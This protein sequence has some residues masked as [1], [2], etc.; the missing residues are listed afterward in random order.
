MTSYEQLVSAVYGPDPGPR[1]MNGSRY[2][3]RRE[4]SE[5]GELPHR[6]FNPS[7]RSRTTSTSVA[8]SDSDEKTPDQQPE[9]APAPEANAGAPQASDTESRLETAKRFLQEDAVKNSPQEK[10]VEF[11]RSKGLTNDEIESLLGREPAQESESSSE[12]RFP[13]SHGR[14][15]IANTRCH[16]PNNPN[17]KKR[18]PAHP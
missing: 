6:P 1:H 7:L 10:K 16:S 18:S 13:R 12:V 5:H 17:I 11:L 9:G 2:S 3:Y 4:P 15:Y 14:T 8:M